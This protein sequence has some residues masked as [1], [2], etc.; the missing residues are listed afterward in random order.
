[1]RRCALLAIL[2][3]ASGPRGAASPPSDQQIL[4]Y[5]NESIGWIRGQS[6]QQLAAQPFDLV[7]VSEERQLAR[8]IVRLSFEVA[9][10]YA[11]LLPARAPSPAGSGANSVGFTPDMLARMTAEAAKQ[12]QDLQAEIDRF[13][14]GF[15]GATS[16]AARRN[17]QRQIAESRSEL[18]L[19]Q[20]RQETLKTF[21]S[22]L[23]QGG[24][25]PGTSGFVQQIDELERAT[26]EAHAPDK[27]GQQGPAPAAE[28][29]IRKPEPTGVLGLTSDVL[30]LTREQRS[31]R[32][33]LESTSRLR[34]A[35][36]QLREPLAADL[37]ATLQ[38]GDQ[39]AAEADTT[40]PAVLHDRTKAIED[41]TA[42]FRKV[43]AALIPLTRQ[44]L[45]LD[46]F[47]ANLD[48]W[49]AA[50]DL[51]YDGE[52]RSLLLRVGLLAVAIG[53]ILAA[54]EFWR[55]ATFRYV[56]DLHR[57]H[58][59]L[60]LRR[61]VVAFA[62][63]L[64]VFFALVTELGSL[65]TFAGFITAGLAVAL[66]NVILSV[67]GYFFLIGKYGVRVGDRVQIAGIAGDVVDIGLVRL[68]L[69]ELGTSGL[70]TGRVVV[71]SNAVLFQPSANFFKQIPGSNFAWHRI[72]VTIAPGSDYRLAEKRL[73]E[74]AAKV[75]DSIRKDID[76]QHQR[77]A[78]TLAIRVD[79]PRPESRLRLTDAGLEIVIRFPVPLDR[80]S[81]ID[82]EM[83]RVLLDAI[84]QEPRLKLAGSQTPAIQVVTETPSS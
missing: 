9:H 43:S 30:A 82:D 75:Y 19:A 4:A 76:E 63:S 80:A 64:F 60:L 61:I 12:V 32:G 49:L 59:F 52:L 20:A 51:Q 50:I 65:A 73:L 83:T 55:R 38:R 48:D 74:A 3:A 47:K 72:S 22:M 39:L 25:A 45:L 33:T 1:M 42:H 79:A 71:I 44:R 67:A 13:Q 37:A 56:Q 29:A 77:I 5:L 70:P 35:A 10:A 21:A 68:H 26:P 81:A 58:Q 62:V 78:Q 15:A 40:D 54:S 24:G 27:G 84:E 69:L 16:A 46:T 66:Q 57:R 53:V 18:Q 23:S 7:F 28:A 11:A 31:L 41:L 17:L 6:A 2:L 34:A 36:D 8:E 14:R